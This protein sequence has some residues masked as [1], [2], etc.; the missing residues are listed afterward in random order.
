MS[1]N[2]T[3]NFDLCQWEP[4]DPVIRTDFNADNEKIDAALT[5]LEEARQK[6]EK[7]RRDLAFYAGYLATA[8]AISVQKYLPQHSLICDAF[9]SST[10]TTVT[11][12]ISR[13]N[14][15]LVISGAGKSGTYSTGELSLRR[16]D[17]TQAR[18]WLH[19]SGGSVAAQLNGTAMEEVAGAASAS[20]TGVF[21]IEREYAWT[22]IG[23]QYVQVDLTLNS[24]SSS[25]MTVYDFFVCF[26]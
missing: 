8:R 2:Y 1:T 3:E 21:C 9:F 7:S 16:S 20:V 25:S 24:G 6:Y 19:S 5:A 12:S 13:Q 14:N 10:G 18:M 4:T 22:G 15:T 23:S 11:G 26:S 17:W